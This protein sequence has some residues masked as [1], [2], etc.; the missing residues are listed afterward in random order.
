MSNDEDVRDVGVISVKQGW[1]QP[2]L[3]NYHYCIEDC[4]ELVDIP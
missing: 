1:M 4:D 2:A 3:V